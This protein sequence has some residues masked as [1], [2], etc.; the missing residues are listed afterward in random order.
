MKEAM[1]YRDK[2]EI[3][4]R[5]LFAIHNE[6]GLG[7]SEEIYHEAFCHWLRDANIPFASK[8]AHHL[9]LEGEIVHTLFPDI[10]A[11]D[12]ITIKL[13]ALPR[14]L[15]DEDKVQVFNYLKR[16]GDRLGLL[17]NMGL[18]RVH[19]ERFIFDAPLA[20]RME[21][22]DSWAGTIPD[23]TRSTGL[24]LRH[25]LLS[26]EQVHGTG[27]G[28]EVV[29]KLLTSS[30]RKAGLRFITKPYGASRYRNNAIGCSPFD[31][32]IIDDQ[33]LFVFTALFDTN[34]FNIHRGRSFM[35]SLGI[36]F[37]VAVNFGKQ[38]LQI[39]ALALP[40]SSIRGTPLASAGFP[41]S[42]KQELIT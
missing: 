15:R 12:S 4:L 26:I 42:S 20:Q 31:C 11:W 30:L 35:R 9:M 6:V 40:P 21:Q 3:L 22:W 18:D 24:A 2:T 34:D 13:K 41:S 17:V 27:Y 8:Q 23:A 14:K 28:S 25:A 10:V 39:H 29:E 38:Y 37:G 1:L 16:R 32:W 33:M 19:V 7:R 5:G 36:P